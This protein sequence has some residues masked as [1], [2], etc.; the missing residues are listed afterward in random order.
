MRP[1]ASHCSKEATLSGTL[2]RAEQDELTWLDLQVGIFP[3]LAPSTTFRKM[4]RK[5]FGKSRS[6]HAISLDALHLSLRLLVPVEGLSEIGQPIHCGSVTGQSGIAVQEPV[7][8]P[9]HCVQRVEQHEHGAQCD[10]PLEVVG[11][12]DKVWKGCRRLPVEGHEEAK[13]FGVAHEQPPHSNNPFEAITK[14]LL[15]TSLGTIE[16][17]ALCV[18]A[19]L[20]NV[21]TEASLVLLQGKP[22]HD[23]ALPD[24]MCHETS[25]S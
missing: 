20:H 13:P 17:N 6:L 22:D 19:K 18:I 23:E 8:A 7:E 10:L 14:T 15:F 16:G 5:A 3:E 9:F 4:D 2:R 24:E 25:D 21:V 12:Q 1:D 11:G